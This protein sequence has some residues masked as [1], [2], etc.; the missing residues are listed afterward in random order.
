MS[1]EMT[2][3]GAG[4][5]LEAADRLKARIAQVAR[6]A[7]RPE[8]LADVGPFAGLFRLTGRRDPVLVASC[9]G[10]GTKARI[11]ALLGAYEG[12]GRDLVALNVNDV[13]TVGAEP[14]FF[15][16]YIASHG[17][18]EE[19]KL[20]LVR[21]MADACREVGCALL[22]GE[23]ADMP[24]IYRPGDF[25]LAG[26]VV[27]VVE[28][29]EL[30]DGSR[31]A[32]GDVLLGLPS[33]GLHTN[34]FSLVRRVLRVGIGDDE[35]A[36]RRRL[37]EYVPELGRTLGEELLRPHR[38]YLR[39]VMAVRG[40]VKGIAH[41]TGGGIEANVARVLPAGLRAA[42]DWGSW[43]VPPIF[44]LLQER[45]RIAD[46]EMRRVFNLGIGMVL[47]VGAEEGERAK[48]VL[49]DSYVL[50]MVQRGP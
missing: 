23:T 29:D 46:D 7:R 35:A 30:V 15:L 27:G 45:G 32:P 44:R 13:L 17:L 4:V 50:G 1:G 43:E 21:G 18:P 5:D 2:Y 11:A 19:A 37:E 10:V 6:L 16:D 48:Q 14:L 24:D 26:F 3:A 22:G 34:G 38:C 40:L 8:V 42:I 47:V 9:D 12:I 33:D 31:I 36:E 41:V 28:R 49:C 39:E 25:D 20:A